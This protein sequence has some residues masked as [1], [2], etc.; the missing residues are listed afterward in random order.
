MNTLKVFILSLL[1]LSLVSCQNHSGLKFGFDTSLFNLLEK[2]DLNRFLV[3]K[4]IAS[5]L[6]FER[7]SFPSYGI[8]VH[9]V[10]ITNVKSPSSVNVEQKRD[11]EIDYLKIT[12]K[13]LSLSLSSSFNIKVIGL[14]NEQAVSTP[15]F[16]QI[17]KIEGDFYFN[18]GEVKFLDFSVEVSNIEM[19]FENI[20]FNTIY[21]IAKSLII[22]VI[23]TQTSKIHSKVETALNSF[24][25]SQM[26]ID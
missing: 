3:N 1:I 20:F 21:K 24:I 2:V 6:H 23:N 18:Q 13:D 4:T 15:I 19:K 25:S 8:E 5:N 26:L 10:N 7:T 9:S 14:F 11:N 16:I 22:N 17:Q 12:L